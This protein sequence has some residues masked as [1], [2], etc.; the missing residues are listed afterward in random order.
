[1]W[2]GWRKFCQFANILKCYA[3]IEGF[4]SIWL[5]LKP[6]LAKYWTNHQAIWS[7]TAFDLELFSA[8]L[9]SQSKRRISWWFIS[10][11]FI[12]NDV[13]LQMFLASLLNVKAVSV[14]HRHTPSRSRRHRHCKMFAQNYNYFSTR[15]S[16]ILFRN[17]RINRIIDTNFHTEPLS[18]PTKGWFGRNEG[19]VRHLGRFPEWRASNRPKFDINMKEVCSSFVS[20]P[21]LQFVP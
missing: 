4:L 1:M 18:P 2:R 10:R 20:T 13:T 21:T 7:H 6:I 5:N 3:I 16:E 19:T 14:T 8:Y 15:E 12:A 9:A 17:D 11:F